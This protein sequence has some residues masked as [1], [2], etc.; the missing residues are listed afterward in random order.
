MEAANSGYVIESAGVDWMTA[1]AYRGRHGER[2]YERS[3]DL[4]SDAARQGNDIRLWR[5]GGYHGKQ[6]AGIISGQRHDTYILKLSSD[7]ARESWRE[8]FQLSSNV[9]RID[10]Q[11]T[12]RLPSRDVAFISRQRDNALEA[13][14][15]RGRKS[16]VTLIQSSSQGDSLYLGQRSSDVYARCYDKGKEQKTDKSGLLIRQELEYKGDRA[17]QVAGV[18]AESPSAGVKSA[19]IVSSY[20]RGRGIQTLTSVDSF[21][22]GARGRVSSD[23]A[24]LRWM[25]AAVRPSI[26]RLLARDRLADVLMALG[27]SDLVTINATG[28]GEEKK[29]GADCNAIR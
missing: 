29:E 18:L 22:V 27:L 28:T 26:I 15:G 16:N 12:F 11:A 9:S 19:S 8:S 17:K 20:M 5:A 10:V 14:S 2:F 25:R 23:I 6:C 24:S 1:T 3:N 21:Y 13:K 4:I 7:D